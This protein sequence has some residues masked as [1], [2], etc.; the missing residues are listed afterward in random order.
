MK[1]KTPAPALEKMVKLKPTEQIMRV[2]ILG[3]TAL[4]PAG[5]IF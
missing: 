2:K 3:A 5:K 4:G 1:L